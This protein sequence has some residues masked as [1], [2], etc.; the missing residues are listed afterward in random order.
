MLKSF[1]LRLRLSQTNDIL[2]LKLR[3]RQMK[4]LSIRLRLR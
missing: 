4:Y 2:I 3:L 1:D